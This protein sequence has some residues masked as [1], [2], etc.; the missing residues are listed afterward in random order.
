MTQVWLFEIFQDDAWT[1]EAPF[2]PRFVFNKALVC[3][4][5]SSWSG[6]IHSQHKALF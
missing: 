5:V 2:Y 4:Y 1:P 6:C 3:M